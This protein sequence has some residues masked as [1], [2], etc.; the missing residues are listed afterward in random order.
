MVSSN[1]LLP[2]AL[3]DQNISSHTDTT[4]F[5]KNSINNSRHRK[6]E[7][8]ETKDETLETKDET[9]E[10]KDETLKT[11]VDSCISLVFLPCSLTFLI[12]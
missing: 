8:L 6:D 11:T 9:L 4:I 10:T 1:P 2:G 12:F 7:T 5:K 3:Q